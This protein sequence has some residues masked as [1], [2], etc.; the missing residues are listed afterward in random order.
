MFMYRNPRSISDSLR[1]AVQVIERREGV[2]SVEFAIIGPVFLL[3]LFGMIS[4]GSVLYTHNNMINAARESAR[5]MAV[6]DLNTTEAEA[7][8]NNYLSNMG[9]TFTVNAQD[10]DPGDPDDVSVNISVPA[11]DVALVNF[12][13]I[14]DGRT[15][16]VT[17]TM[18]KE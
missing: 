4:F 1:R 18:L 8:A 10:P 7:Y 5:R 17:V 11:E 13:G 2:S 15:L 14:F 16:Q 3:I 6:G 9:V 12:P